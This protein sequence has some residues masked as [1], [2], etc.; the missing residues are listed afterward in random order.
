MTLFT[1]MLEGKDTPE[2]DR[3]RVRW[4]PEMVEEYLA[5]VNGTCG[6]CEHCEREP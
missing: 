5:H 6:G 3:P 1:K 2:P 4:S